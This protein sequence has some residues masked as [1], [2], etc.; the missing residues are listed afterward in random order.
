MSHHFQLYCCQFRMVEGTHIFQGTVAQEM[1]LIFNTF[2]FLPLQ[3][4]LLWFLQGKILI[5]ALVLG[6]NTD[7]PTCPLGPLLT[8]LFQEPLNVRKVLKGGI[9]PSPRYLFVYFS[10][11]LVAC[12]SRGF[13]SSLFLF[14][15]FV[16]V[17]PHPPPPGSCGQFTCFS[18]T[19]C[20]YSAALLPLAPW[21]PDCSRPRTL[22]QFLSSFLSP[23][24]A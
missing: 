17:S 23:L 3:L 15:S 12:S 18:S 16:S 21:G 6:P 1:S 13:A 19:S 14:S 11:C 4:F 7:T 2:F 8:F 22:E 9:L 10:V 5:P 24:D 20:I